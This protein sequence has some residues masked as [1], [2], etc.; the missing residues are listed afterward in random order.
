[1]L[2]QGNADYEEKFGF[3]FI[4][5]ATGKSAKEMSDLLQARLP[6]NREQ[7]IVNAAEEQRKIFQLRIN[8][9][10]AEG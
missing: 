3:I 4:I 9:A 6:N 10:L 8:K 7:E 1:M 2:S 5:C